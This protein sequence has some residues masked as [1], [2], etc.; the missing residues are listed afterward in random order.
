MKKSVDFLGGLSYNYKHCG[1]D[2]MVDVLVLEASVE[3]RVGS[4]PTFR[5]KFI[6]GSHMWVF[7]LSIICNCLHFKVVLYEYPSL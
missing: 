7:F 1:S 5:T 6:K 2:E 3:R 4:S